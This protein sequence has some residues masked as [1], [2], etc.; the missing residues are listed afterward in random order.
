[1]YNV[2]LVDNE[3]FILDGLEVLVDWE[4]LNLNVIGKAHN[5]EDA[6]NIIKHTYVDIL[7][8]DIKMPKMNGLELI[9]KAEEFNPY[10]KCIILSGYNDFKFLKQGIKLG[11]ENYLTKPVNIDELVSTLKNIV[12]NLEN[13]SSKSLIPTNN[14]WIILRNNILSR[15]ISNTITINELNNK[16]DLLNII[17]DSVA[18]NVAIINVPLNSNNEKASNIYDVCYNYI[19]SETNIMSFEDMDGNYILVFAHN[20]STD[21][22]S[23]IAFFLTKL[24]NNIHSLNVKVYITLGSTITTPKDLHISYSS[25]KKL[26]EYFLIYPHM[27]VI[28]SEILDKEDFDITQLSIDY[29]LISNTLVSRNQKHLF[30]YVDKLFEDILHMNGITPHY[31]KLVVIEILLNLYKSFSSNFVLFQAEVMNEHSNLL[32]N[33]HDIN[34]FETIK[35]SLKELF[36]F[37]MNKS[38]EKEYTVNPVVYQ[39]LETIHKNYNEELSLK[40]LSYKF[41]INTTYL[42]QLFKKETGTSFPNYLNNYRIDKAKQF[43]LESNLKTSQIAKKIG[44]Q[45]PNYFYRIFKKYTGISPTDFK[46]T[47]TILN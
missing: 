25:A 10:C 38:A 46:S 39:I 29:N 18:Y 16:A 34:D 15:W 12:F 36:V 45:D 42:G 26:L 21:Y 33:L 8:S 7:I 27:K 5:G 32:T 11:I 9:K 13:T 23:Y 6:L 47:K 17:I 35:A 14:E 28:T 37:I 22:A 30:E 3:P 40:T 31:F 41:N 4:N 1:M 2:L 44:Y 20:D 24:Y 43:L 19:Q